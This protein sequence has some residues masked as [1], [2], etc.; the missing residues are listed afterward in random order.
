MAALGR[1]G[2]VE[3]RPGTS[4]GRP[5]EDGAVAVQLDGKVENG[6]SK[7]KTN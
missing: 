2:Q 4:T 5:D 3:V 7:T 1:R 6:K